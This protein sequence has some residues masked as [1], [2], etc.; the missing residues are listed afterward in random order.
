[1]Q[2]TGMSKSGLKQESRVGQ[3]KRKR[4]SLSLKATAVFKTPGREETFMAK[5]ALKP[6]VTNDIA[7]LK[8]YACVEPKEKMAIFVQHQVTEPKEKIYRVPGCLQL[9]PEG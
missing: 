9:I 6:V 2:A 7:Y 8:N 3:R 1:M 5:L 4:M